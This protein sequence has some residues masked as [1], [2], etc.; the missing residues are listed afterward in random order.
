M[1]APQITV[2][3]SFPTTPSMAVFTLD[4]PVKG[5]LDGVTYLLGGD[6]TVIDITNTVQRIAIRRGRNRALDRFEPGR[7]AVQVLDLDGTWNPQNTSSIFYPN[8]QVRRTIRVSASLNGTGYT[9]FSGLI[10]A[11]G[12]DYDQTGTAAFITLEASDVLSQFSQL[13]V[14]TIAGTSAGQLSGAR[15]GNILDTLGGTIATTDRHIDTG[16]TTLLADPATT[17]TG[18]DA[19]QTVVDSEFGAF[20]VTG[21]GGLR[22]AD[23]ST[24]VSQSQIVDA[25]FS[26]VSAEVGYLNARLAFDDTLLTN[27]CTVTATGLAAQTASDATSQTSFG[28]R[29]VSRTD[30][31]MNSTTNA[32]NQAQYIIGLRS[33]PALRVE[34]IELDT[35]SGDDQAQQALGLDLLDGIVLEHDHCGTT[36]TFQVAVQGVEHDITPGSWRTRLR[37]AEAYPGFVLDVSLLDTGVLTY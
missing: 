26:S 7:C 35:W 6:E 11:F 25:T 31:L 9:L 2:E 12:Y 32:L 8:I 14:S 37:L 4:D 33:T 18:L 20:F 15:I 16:L 17:R 5:L 10:E 34:S 36:M 24:L 30:L 1:T 13:N 29:S 3:V 27:E 19:I 28:K 22:Y 23:R 21:D